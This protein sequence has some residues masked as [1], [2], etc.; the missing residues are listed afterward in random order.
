[1]FQ[2]GC[3]RSRGDTLRRHIGQE[4]AVDYLYRLALTLAA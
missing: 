1:M 3:G 2:M 4:A